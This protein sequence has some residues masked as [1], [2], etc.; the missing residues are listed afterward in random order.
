MPWVNIMSEAFIFEWNFYTAVGILGAAC[1]LVRYVCVT[2]DRL[3]S[4]SPWYYLTSIVA[5]SLVLFGLWHTMNFVAI[6]VQCIYISL[7]FVG[8]VRHHGRVRQAAAARRSD[9]ALAR[10]GDLPG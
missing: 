6:S 10:L 4:Q 1:I 2:F 3:P 5:A 8:L 7:S 9:M